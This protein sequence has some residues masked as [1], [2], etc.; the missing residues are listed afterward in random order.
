MSAKT[1][2]VRPG[3]DFAMSREPGKAAVRTPGV[4]ASP[5]GLCSDKLA[6]QSH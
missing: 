4:I 5:I 1:G 3:E 6:D 2:A